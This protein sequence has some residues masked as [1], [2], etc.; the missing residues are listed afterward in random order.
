VKTRLFRARAQIQKDLAR[1]ADDNLSGV[2]R[3]LAERCDRI[4][5][6]VLV[7]LRGLPAREATTDSGLAEP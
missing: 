3:F 1:T 6:N 4:V 7:S 2:H 5:S